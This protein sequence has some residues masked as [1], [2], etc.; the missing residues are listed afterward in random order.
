MPRGHMLMQL[1]LSC[2]RRAHRFDEEMELVARMKAVGD[3]VEREGYPDLLLFQARG[4]GEEVLRGA[5][6]GGRQALGDR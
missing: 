6:R 3:I 2:A 5:G 1:L 4:D